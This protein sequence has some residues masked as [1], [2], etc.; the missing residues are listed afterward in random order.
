MFMYF[1]I[2]FSNILKSIR[3]SSHIIS[4]QDEEKNDSLWF[5]FQKTKYVW[6]NERKCF[7]GLQF[8]VNQSLSTYMEW[9]G[10]QEESDI[11]RAENF[12]GK[13]Q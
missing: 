7:Q 5:T 6:S 8:P 13:N 3:N 4:Y 10:Y 1:S 2:F 9:K 12:Y 11:Q